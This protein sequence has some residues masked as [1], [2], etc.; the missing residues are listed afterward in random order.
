MKASSR[1]DFSRARNS[2]LEWLSGPTEV[3]PTHP[4]MSIK[5]LREHFPDGL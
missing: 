1:S 3:G 5:M 4:K 2:F